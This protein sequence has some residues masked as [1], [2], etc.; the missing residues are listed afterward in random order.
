MGDT[1]SAAAASR[2][3]VKIQLYWASRGLS[4]VR[5]WAEPLPTL[6]EE[7]KPATV[8]QVRS[9]LAEILARQKAAACQS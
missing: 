5:A 1:L 9:N 6:D 7:G 3:A 8:F 2:L 4:G